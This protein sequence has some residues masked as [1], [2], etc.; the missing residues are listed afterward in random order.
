MARKLGGTTGVTP[1]SP[2]TRPAL[3]VIVVDPLHVVRAG[4]TLLIESQGDLQVVGHAASS[5]E[6]LQLARRAR[7]RGPVLVLVGLGLSGEHDAFWL[8]RAIRERCPSH[9]IVASGANAERTRISR[10]LFVGA[11]GFLDHSAEPTAFLDGIRRAAQGEVV[12]TGMPRDWLKPIAR[13]LDREA[14]PVS[15]LTAREREVLSVAAEG[16]TARQIATRLGMRERTV[17]THL[18]HIYG[19][20]GVGGRVEALSAAARAGL[21]TV[22]WLG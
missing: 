18:G 10:A 15:A 20:L 14:A 8:I 17:T 21:V 1:P 5:D 12:L 3:G 19:K 13:G 6:A 9:T 4:L 11:D 22:G 16:L 2:A 7:H